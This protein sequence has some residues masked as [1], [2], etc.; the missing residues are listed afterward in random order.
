[1]ITAKKVAQYVIK[2]FHESEDLITNLKLQKLLYYIQGWHLGLYGKPLFEED[3]Q[4]WVHGP[5]QPVVYG[6]YKRYRWNP[7]SE[8]I[9]DIELPAEA[10]S[11]IDEVLET[12]G[13]ESAYMLERRTHL[14][15]PW[16]CARGTLSHE[17][18]C[19]NIISKD[20]MQS[21]FSKLANEKEG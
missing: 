15:Q 19:T 4:A 10:R 9:P 20:S 12:Y 8:D 17:Q 11:H 14:E 16:L 3:F 5:V 18:D 6:E 13:V 21:Y 2:F 1:M 7:I